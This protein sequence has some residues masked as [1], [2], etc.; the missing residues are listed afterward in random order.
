MREW[1]VAWT[2]VLLLGACDDAPPA[3]DVRLDGVL[4]GAGAAGR[5]RFE[6]E[7]HPKSPTLGEH[8]RVVTTLR[9]GETGAPVEGAE[10]EVDATMPHHGHGMM[11]VPEHREIGEGRYE[12]R[13]MK[14]HMHG[15]WVLSATARTGTTSDSIAIAFEQPPR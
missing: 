9:D 15:R 12:S 1:G 8:F 3:E 13:G 7:P 6:L 11:T 4:E 5:F 10:V 2:V 14:L